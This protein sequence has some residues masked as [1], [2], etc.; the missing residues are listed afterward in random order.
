MIE[1]KITESLRLEKRSRAVWAGGPATLSKAPERFPRNTPR[2]LVSGKGCKVWD[3][4]GNM[5]YDTISGLGPILLGHC[6]PDVDDAVMTQVKKGVCFSLPHVFELEAAELLCR[7]IVAAEL[8]RFTKNGGDATQAA[9][10]IAREAT[11]KKHIICCG[12]HGMHDWYMATTPMNGGILP[13]VG[14][15]SHQVQWG[16]R[17]TLARIINDYYRDIAGIIVEVPPKPWGT[18]DE[19]FTMALTWLFNLSREVEAVFILD[20]VVTGFRYGLSGAHGRF[21]VCA[22]LV[23]LGK[24]LANGYEL[25]AIVGRNDLMGFFDGGNVFLSTTNGG[26]AVALAAC[27]ASVKKFRSNLLRQNFEKLGTMLGDGLQSIF[28]DYQLPVT[29]NGDYARMVIN[30]RD[31]L[32]SEPRVSKEQLRTLWL[33]DMIKQGVLFGGPTFPMMCYTKDDVAFILKAADKVAERIRYAMNT[34][35]VATLIKG[36][37]VGEVFRQRYADETKHGEEDDA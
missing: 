35:K 27:I 9:V 28:L 17:E 23:C 25:A 14:D 5:Y 15:Y 24:G 30:W 36:P 33:Q 4:D 8:V 16:D 2:F 31:A 3:V 37:L 18:P 13:F 32:H 21:G 7:H 19:Y 10:R 29:L 11:G 34:N 22:D 6:D 12:Y 26:A 1:S 20:E